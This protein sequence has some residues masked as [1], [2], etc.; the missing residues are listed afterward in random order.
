[1]TFEE[2]NAIFDLSTTA[3]QTRE[4]LGLLFDSYFQLSGLS[5]AEQV[6]YLNGYARIQNVLASVLNQIETIAD[7]L[8]ALADIKPV[9]G[10]SA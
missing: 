8:D 5:A 7:G 4:V 10:E 3:D 6:F 2:N 1:M 9:E